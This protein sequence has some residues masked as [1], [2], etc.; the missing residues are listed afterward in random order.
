MHN[1]NRMNTKKRKKM[2][3]NDIAGLVTETETFHGN[4]KIL[5]IRNT[6]YNYKCF[7]FIFHLLVLFKWLLKEISAE[8]KRG[9]IR[10]FIDSVHFFFK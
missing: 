10:R 3:V 8:P 6:S 1:L 7:Y 5:I 4:Y 9:L 2:R